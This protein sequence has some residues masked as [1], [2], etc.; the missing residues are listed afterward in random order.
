MQNVVVRNYGKVMLFNL[1][2]NTKLWQG[3]SKIHQSN[4]QGMSKVYPRKVMINLNIEKIAL[5][6][7]KIFRSI[8][9]I[10]SIKRLY[11]TAYGKFYFS[12]IGKYSLKFLYVQ[13]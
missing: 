6:T 8:C 12:C 10:G 5:G 13:K 3:T 11:E 1:L 4:I 7:F 9:D 2:G